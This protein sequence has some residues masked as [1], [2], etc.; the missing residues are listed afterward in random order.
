[1]AGLPPRR[2]RAEGGAEG[3]AA[4]EG[5]L[6]RRQ[7][8]HLG[9]R[10]QAPR[11]PAEPGERV[12]RGARRHP[13]GARAGDRSPLQGAGGRGRGDGG[14]GWRHQEAAPRRRQGHRGPARALRDRARPR[15]PH[16]GR[17]QGPP[18]AQDPRRRDAVARAARQ[19]RRLLRGR[20][21]CRRHQAADRPHRLRRG[22]DQA[23]R[24]DRPGRVRPQAALRPAQAE[25]HQAPQDRRLV[26]PPRRARPAAQ[27]PEGD[28]PRRRA[29]DPAGA[30]P[31][32][33]ARRRPLR[34]VGPQR[35]VPPGDQ[36]QQPPRPPAQPRGAGDHRQ[37]READAAG[38]RRRAVRQRP[39][40]P[41]RHRA[42]QPSAE[43]AVGHAEGQAG[44][45][46]PEPA[47]QARRLLGPLGHRGRPDAAPAPVRPARS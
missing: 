10:R 9:R 28:D 22:G 13:E 46:P 40:R 23:P 25:G 33:P 47:R 17:V 1:M 27:R 35:P 16:V 37:Q 43:V 7:P 21:R 26:Q 36:P 19:V 44:P 29:G 32:G 24:G 15:R 6:L 5:H 39:P 41:P 31:D 45:V 12:P 18:L 38:G 42:G 11:G 4:R 3:Q 30:A 2:H 20:H 34:H 14:R 8:R